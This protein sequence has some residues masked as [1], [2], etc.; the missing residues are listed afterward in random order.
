MD[1]ENFHACGARVEV[2]CVRSRSFRT[3]TVPVDAA[4][5]SISHTLTQ[6]LPLLAYQAA[7]AGHLG[8][9]FC[10]EPRERHCVNSM[11]IRH[12]DGTPPDL[13][14]QRAKAKYDE[15]MLA[16]LRVLSGDATA[17]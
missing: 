7:C 12:V 11:S 14:E 6:A 17:F 8:H 1:L 16:A 2:T 15:T 4:R 5:F 10:N 9:V 13:P 3:H